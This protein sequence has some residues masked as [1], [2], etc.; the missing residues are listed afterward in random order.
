[1]CVSVRALSV[2]MYTQHS[3]E[4]CEGN[5]HQDKNDS[6]SFWCGAVM[7]ML[8]VIMCDFIPMITFTL[9]CDVRVQVYAYR[10]LSRNNFCFCF[11]ICFHFY[12]FL[13]RSLTIRC[14]KAFALMSIEEIYGFKLSENS[15]LKA[16]IL[17]FRWNCSLSFV[18]FHARTAQHTH[19]CL[20][21]VWNVCFGCDYGWSSLSTASRF[22]S[23]GSHCY[24]VCF[25]C[26]FLHSS[27]HRTK[28]RH[29]SICVCGIKSQ[30]RWEQNHTHTH[31]HT[32]EEENGSS[33]LNFS[34]T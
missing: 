1:M 31:S 16:I 20:R 9:L 4:L 14:A 15:H 30:L 32:Q 26:F 5:V 7:R 11:H 33:R 17:L 6:M 10:K 29:V 22:H 34:R 23:I 19:I 21:I 2:Q 28:W 12:L 24:D 18:V 25:V 27:T 13:T 8:L 3:Y